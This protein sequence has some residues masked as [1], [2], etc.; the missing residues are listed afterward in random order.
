[1]S[2][3]RWLFALGI[4]TGV[5]CLLVGQRMA[6]TLQGYRLGA[7][8]RETH[9]RGG[10]VAWLETQVVNLSSPVHLAA[11]AK[12]RKLEL[13]ARHTVIEDAPARH[14]FMRIAAWLGGSE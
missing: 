11:V 7:D 14:P 12:E 3:S 8:V 10:E 13:V 9:Q 1:M 6:L 5:G 2:L 4:M